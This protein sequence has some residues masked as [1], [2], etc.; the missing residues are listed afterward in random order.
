MARVCHGPH[1]I[2]HQL[3]TSKLPLANCNYLDFAMTCM[4]GESPS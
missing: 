1:G 4:A 3:Q 2:M